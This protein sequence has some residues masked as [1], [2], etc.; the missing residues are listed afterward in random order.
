MCSPRID[1]DS[2]ELRRLTDEE[3]EVHRILKRRQEQTGRLVSGYVAAALGVLALAV[4]M[5]MVADSRHEFGHPLSQGY[6]TVLGFSIVLGV[7]ASA[8]ACTWAI[9]RDGRTRAAEDDKIRE[10][11]EAR[12]ARAIRDAIRVFLRDGDAEA[13]ALMERTQQLFNGTDGGN[14]HP[15][16]HRNRG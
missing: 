15:F 13:Q 16:Q 4:W 8:T 2:Q 10:H 3:A 7:A 11:H 12:Q 14:V 9:V 5:F 1:Q 6:A